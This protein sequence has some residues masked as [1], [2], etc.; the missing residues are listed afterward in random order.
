[1]K[2]G[3]INVQDSILSLEAST[4]MLDKMLHW[5]I[6]NN[7]LTMPSHSDMEAFRSEVMDDLKARYPNNSPEPE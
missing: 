3:D 6:E 7:N 2:I 1:M 5:V 4:A